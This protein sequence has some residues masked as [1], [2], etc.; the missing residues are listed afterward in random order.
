MS[1]S[2]LPNYARKPVQAFTPKVGGPIHR[3]LVGTRSVMS[4]SQIQWHFHDIFPS[5]IVWQILKATELV[6]EVPVDA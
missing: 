1:R 6:D 2:W 3:V 5:M 4:R